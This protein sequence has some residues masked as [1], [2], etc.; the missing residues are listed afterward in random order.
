MNVFRHILDLFRRAPA[1][2]VLERRRR[3][4]M[5]LI[6]ENM[7][8]PA[9]PLCGAKDYTLWTIEANWLIGRAHQEAMM[10]PDEFAKAERTRKNAPCHAC[11]RIAERASLRRFLNER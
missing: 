10:D 1:P 3:E 8:R 4:V 9:G 5:H 6:P 2:P 7:L 11:A